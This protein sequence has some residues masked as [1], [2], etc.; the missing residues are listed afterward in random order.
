MRSLCVCFFHVPARSLWA[1]R[2]NKSSPAIQYLL[3]V[4][5]ARSDRVLSHARN[6]LREREG[7]KIGP[8]PLARSAPAA[9]RSAAENA[10]GN[11]PALLAA[12]KGMRLH[13]LYNLFWLILY[14]YWLW[15]IEPHTKNAPKIP[16]RFF[17]VDTCVRYSVLKSSTAFDFPCFM[18][19]YFLIKTKR[20]WRTSFHI[21]K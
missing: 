4:P 21:K 5:Q 16:I 15:A 14:I 17:K 12:S 9:S 13:N 2:S 8:Q 11:S 20:V 6:W 1:S 18:M 7:G 10:M 3:W 19:S